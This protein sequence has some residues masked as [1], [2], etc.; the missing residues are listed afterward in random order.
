MNGKQ[1]RLRHISRKNKFVLIP[2]DH[3]LSMGPLEGIEQPEKTIQLVASGGAT[4]VIAHKG[5]WTRLQEVPSTGVIVQLS[6]STIYSAPDNKVQVGTVQEVVSLGADA[7]SIHVN[8]GSENESE[9]LEMFGEISWDCQ[10]YGIP[11]VAMMYPRGP[12]IK[13]PF[14]PKIVAHVARIGSELGADV[15][16]TLYTGSIDT[17]RKVVDVCSVPVVVA[18]GSKIDSIP[19]FLQMMRDAMEA[20]ASGVA[21]GR[22]IWQHKNTQKITEAV[23]SIVLDGNTSKGAAELLD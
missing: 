16:K 22:N 13:D 3:G 14:D 9:M 6:G 17:F 11:L 7:V 19:K 5:V 18:G 15:V 21:V 10:E 4:G 20:G 2:L 12:A 8:I 1:Y 23:C